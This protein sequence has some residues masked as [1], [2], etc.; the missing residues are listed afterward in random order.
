[1]Y[2]ALFKFLLAIAIGRFVL[3]VCFCH[4]VI[5]SPAPLAS[6]LTI[7]SQFL[8]K[9]TKHGSSVTI[10]SISLK[11]S[12]SF[13]VH[14]QSVFRFY[15]LSHPISFLRK[16]RSKSARNCFA[17]RDNFNCLLDVGGFKCKIILIVWFFAFLLSFISCPGLVVSFIKIR[18]FC[19]SPCIRHLEV[20]LVSLIFL[21][22]LFF[23]SPCHLYSIV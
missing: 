22:V 21:S 2:W 16:F 12:S 10:F 1:M 19:R 7:L 18:I 23:I 15:K 8:A 3:S 5:P 13:L 20:S 17:P 6:I 11:S 14:F 4:R 9:C